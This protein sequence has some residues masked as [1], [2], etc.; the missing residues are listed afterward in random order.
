M[1]LIL[2]RECQDVVR[3]IEDEERQCKC[4]KCKGQY[5]DDLNAWYEGEKCTPLGFANSSL[6]NAVMNQPE[7]DWGKTF[8]AFVIEKDCPT[9]ENRTKTIES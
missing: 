5:I 2:C 4:G 1:K 8:T 9:F 6:V 3:L 7:K